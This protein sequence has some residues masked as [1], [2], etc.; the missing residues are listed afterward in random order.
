MQNLLKEKAK[1]RL[2]Y[3][4]SSFPISNLRDILLN[5]L[6]MG[7]GD[8]VRRMP[9]CLECGD[10]IRYGRSDKKFCCDKCRMSHNNRA[11]RNGKA[12]RRKIL[13]QLEKNYVILDSLLK[14]GVSSADLTDLVASGFVAEIVTS[15][16]KLRTHSEYSCFDIKYILTPSKVSC[17]SK[18]QNV[19]V[20]L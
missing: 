4:N 20:S 14:S 11:A 1:D 19:S 13:R 7:Y 2:A 16:R 15:H 5:D 18:I 8:I 6:Q 3:L 10:K 12:F 17:I 9:V